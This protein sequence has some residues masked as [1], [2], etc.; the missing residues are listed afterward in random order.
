MNYTLVQILSVFPVG[1]RRAAVLHFSFFIFLLFSFSICRSQDYRYSHYS[2]REGLGNSMVYCMVQDKDG[3]MWFGT[4]TGLSRFDGTHFKTFTI[5]DGL[6]VNAVLRLY[7]DSKGRVWI[8]PFKETICYYYKGKIYHE[9]NDTLLRRIRLTDFALGCVETNDQEIV[10]LDRRKIFKITNDTLVTE[11]PCAN[12]STCHM[13]KLTKE[14]DRI[15]LQDENGVYYSDD[16]L[17]H[18]Q[19]LKDM[20]HAGAAEGQTLVSSNLVCFVRSF[21]MLHVISDRYALEYD[22]RMPSINSIRKMND[23]T[24]WLNTNNGTFVFDIVRKKIIEHLLAN[25]NIS[26]CFVDN[27]GGTWFSTLNDGVYRVH[28]RLVRTFESFNNTGKKL[29]VFYLQKEGKDVLVGTDIGLLRMVEKEKKYELI[30]DPSYSAP[31]GRP[32]NGI[33]IKEGYKVAYSGSHI[34]LSKGGKPCNHATTFGA[35][36]QVAIQNN[37]MLVASS[38]CIYLYSLPDLKVLKN[39]YNGRTTSMLLRSDTFYFGTLS[40]LQMLTVDGKIRPLL[41]DHPEL[42]T[43]VSSLR[44]DSS[45]AIWM[46]TDFGVAHLKDNK[47]LAFYNMATGLNSDDCRSVVPDQDGIW[48]GTDRGLNKVHTDGSGKV[49]WYTASDGLASDMVNVLLVSGNNIIAGTPEGISFFDKRKLTTGSRCDLRILNVSING[50]GGQPAPYY[51]MDYNNRN[52]RLDYVGLSY[53]SEGD[54][55]YSYRLVGFDTAWKHTNQTT[56]DFIAL[57]AGKYKLELFAT[58]KFGVNSETKFI[59]LRIGEPFWQTAWFILLSVLVIIGITWLLAAQWNKRLRKKER[60]ERSIQE[61]L[62]ELEQKALRAQMNPHFIFNSLNSIQGFIMDNDADSANKYLSSFARLIRQTLDNSMHPVISVE[63][64]LRYLSTY[65]QLEELRFKNKFRWEAK[66]DSSVAVSQAFIP[67]MV[68]QPFV[69]NAIRHGIQN[70]QGNDGKVDILFYREGE[71][72]C[73]K[74]T[75]NGPGRAVSQSIKTGQHIEYQS[76]GMDLTTERIDIL[77]TQLRQ[78]ISIDVNDIT[79]EAGVVTG[80]EVVLRFPVV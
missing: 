12:P 7:A 8:M 53:G 17:L 32:V 15:L 52:I 55:Q 77:N 1:F 54:I 59:E 44:E 73:C 46:T 21:D 57:P 51:E 31:F 36:K 10:I 64:E 58:N 78:Q 72:L 62:Q 67:G 19:R 63:D 35:I 24:I 75:D 49:E 69:E 76:R 70:R 80:T 74:I 42:G 60:T 23:S 66:A 43:K 20:M 68:I 41:Q 30:Q 18:F 2:S 9:N 11:Y 33:Y 16:K 56:L 40:G 38:A 25:K 28:S 39:L 79:D 4:E 61:K 5:E 45:G 13:T 14:G 34:F 22:V 6:P 26:N 3:F 50:V 71:W 27:E 65:L 48:I 29:S 47:L 37:R